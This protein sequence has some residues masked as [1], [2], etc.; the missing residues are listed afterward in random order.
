MTTAVEK[1]LASFDALSEAEKQ[2]A[3]AAILR[4]TAQ[5]APADM[6]EDALVAAAEDLFL[7][8]DAREAAD[9]QREPR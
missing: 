7:D 9:A 3:A 1:L 4:R 5:L 8:L 2:E 6:P